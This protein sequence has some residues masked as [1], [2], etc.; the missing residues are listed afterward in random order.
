MSRI[1]LVPLSAERL[2]E[3]MAIEA[4]AFGEDAWS[5]QS[6][7]QGMMQRAGHY[8][9]AIG[10]G[11]LLGYMGFSHVFEE[12][13]LLTV[14]V[15]KSARRSGVGRQMIKYLL[16]YAKE[17]HA[18]RILLEVRASNAAA[19]GLYESFGFEKIGM[20]KGYYQKPKEDAILYEWT[21]EVGDAGHSS[22]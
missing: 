4:E 1:E 7:R 2:P 10:E 15:A 13:E 11:K 9:A 18:E 5:Q 14:A 8:I 22:V 21:G 19:M 16:D 12:M 3:V 6:F 17:H 20:R